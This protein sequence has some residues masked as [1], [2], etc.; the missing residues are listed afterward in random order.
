M[1][2]DISKYRFDSDKELDLKDFNQCEKTLY[3]DEELQEKL[4]PEMTERLADLHTK[5]HAEEKKGIVLILQAMDAAGKDEIIAFIFK[6]LLPQG[7]KITSSHKPSEVEVKHD[8]L[9][10]SHQALPERGQISVL[11][12]SYYEEI[13]ALLAKDG[14]GTI[15]DHGERK[16]KETW[17]IRCN[18]INQYEKYL[19]ESGFPIIKIFP[20]ISKEAQRDRLLERMKDP[21]K[22][23][24]FSFSDIED[25]RRWDVFQDSY[26]KIIKKTSTP[27]APWYILPADNAW[28]SRLLAGEIALDLLKNINPKFPKIS[29]EDKKRLEKAIQE[30]ENEK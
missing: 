18:H 22:N 24:E 5:F 25:R 29:G 9:W 3:S 27:W 14:E 8:F 7:L 26:E 30:L 6:Y 23:W 16:D 20:Y 15:P 2:I 10:R 28:Y 13:L 19:V 4:I 17:E 12:R 1:K 21:E 11:N